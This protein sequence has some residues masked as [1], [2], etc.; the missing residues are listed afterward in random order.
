M[1]HTIITICFLL[2]LFS[3][4][5]ANPNDIVWAKYGVEQHADNMQFSGDGNFLSVF[6]SQGKIFRVFDTKKVAPPLI[7][8]PS[9]AAALYTSQFSNDN[10]FVGICE[11][12][13]DNHLN[14]KEWTL[15]DRTLSKQRI[16]NIGE[17][18]AAQISPTLKYISGPDIR[19][20]LFVYDIDAQNLISGKFMDTTSVCYATAFTATG[21]TM[22]VCSSATL[23]LFNIKTGLSDGE[24]PLV[25]KS[26]TSISISGN[27]KYIAQY[28]SADGITIITNLQTRVRVAQFP[29]NSLGVFL[30]N[31]HYFYSLNLTLHDFDLTKK[32]TLSGFVE[33]SGSGFAAIEIGGKS[34]IAYLS[35]NSLLTYDFTASKQI[36]ELATYDYHSYFCN[37]GKNMFSSAPGIVYDAVSGKE[38]YRN[39]RILDCL[40]DTS[41]YY[42]FGEP[43]RL[44]MYDLYSKK[45]VYTI[46]SDSLNQ[47]CFLPNLDY[48]YYVADDGSCHIYK[49]QT[50]E[51]V[52]TIA[53]YLPII[54]SKNS[55]YIAFCSY[56][57]SVDSLV[58]NVVELSTGTQKLALS[59]RYDKTGFN[60]YVFSND[61]KSLFTRVYNE[62]IKKY[63]IASGVVAKDY[64]GTKRTNESPASFINISSDDKFL[65]FEDNANFFQVMNLET[66]EFEYNYNDYLNKVSFLEISPDMNYVHASFED[67]TSILWKARFGSAGVNEQV[68]N[69]KVK[70]YPNPVVNDIIKL[71]L[72]EGNELIC[73]IDILDNIGVLIHSFS[74]D[75][76]SGKNQLELNLNPR[77]SSG[78]YF[79]KI[80]FADSVSVVPFVITK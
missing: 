34:I 63:D 78:I 12:E 71:Y 60:D 45:L 33:M 3:I 25:S 26:G 74:S 75:E 69:Q 36:N 55:K 7:F 11:L 24:I 73:K 79:M 68:T 50:N 54:F 51:K 27:S 35:N 72:P 42:Q 31:N 15:T 59:V 22:V 2:I 64:S 53:N 80:Q 30:G 47:N 16:I 77:M 1:K 40:T 10:K 41:I 67:G 48:Y 56:G 62:N 18:T 32:D 21:D 38:Y 8:N 65:I 14:Y 29:S 28:N 52:Y 46:T 66:S 6:Y 70:L 19:E 43:A 76:L 5:S 23:Y 44:E 37:K 13:S 20:H 4:T 61:E 17:V 57:Q 9:T 49:T 39:T 58:I